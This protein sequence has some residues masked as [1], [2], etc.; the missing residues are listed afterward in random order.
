VRIAGVD[1]P[2]CAHFGMPAQPYG[3]EAKQFLTSQILGK[4]VR[5]Q[6]LK[7]DQYARCV[8]MSWVR[9]TFWW[10]NISSMM[11]RRGMAAVYEGA[12][13]EYGGMK[14]EF[15]QLEKGAKRMKKGMWSK[16]ASHRET[17]MQFKKRTKEDKAK[18]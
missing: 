1:A 14:E 10:D 15:L 9:H 3:E 8:G 17:P 11:L 16:R 18:S 6:V 13:A 5:V 2:E 7:R 12:G 4:T